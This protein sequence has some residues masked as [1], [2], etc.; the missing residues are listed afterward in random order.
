MFDKLSEELK[1]ARIRSGLSLQQL[2]AKSRIDLKF[3][4]YIEDGNFSFLPE[5][6]VKAFLKEYVRFVGLDEKVIFKKYEAYKV[7]KEYIEPAPESLFDKIKELKENRL[8]KEKET[9]YSK[10]TSYQPTQTPQPANAFNLSF[11]TDKRNVLFVSAVVGILAVFLLV[12]WLFIHKSTEIV[13]EK[14]YDELVNESKDRYIENE[15]VK[16]S[17]DSVKSDSLKLLVTASD[18]CWVKALIDDSKK[19]EF[20]LYPHNNKLLSAASNFKITFG[21]SYKVQLQLNNRPLKFDAKSKVSSVS[22]DNKGL[23]YLTQV[24]NQK[25]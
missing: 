25:K 23:N 19:E 10:T 4:E 3:L 5:L 24:I 1:A 9:Q 7:G 12:Y 18:S 20:K 6:Y 17:V 16:A 14:P 15:P 13:V 21:N 22:I 2:A 8:E 11:L